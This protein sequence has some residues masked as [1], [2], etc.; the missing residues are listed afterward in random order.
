MLKPSNKCR[1]KKKLRKNI[2]GNLE[3]YSRQNCQAATLSTW[4]VSLVR[5]SGPFFKLTRK[6]LKQMDQSTRKLITMHKALHPRDD[7]D[8]LYVSRKEGGRGLTSVED[9][10][11]ASIQRLKD[12]IEKHEGGLITASRNETENMMYNRKTINRKQKL[13]EKQLYGRFKRLITN[14]SHD[15]TWTSLRNGNFKR[16]TESHLIATQNNVIR[17]NHMKARIDQTQ[18]NC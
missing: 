14:I 16:E 1:G 3:S 10:V 5:Y 8:R 12:Y 18:Q 7:F 15:K 17:I 6:E 4:A 9:S 11:D 13:E 2:S